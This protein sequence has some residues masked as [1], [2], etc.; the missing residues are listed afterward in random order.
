MRAFITHYRIRMQAC[1]RA[2]FALAVLLFSG[3]LSVLY[4]PT[5][6]AP[7]VLGGPLLSAEQGINEGALL[8]IWIYIWPMLA[9]TLARGSSAADDREAMGHVLLPALPVGMKTRILAET[10]LVLTVVLVLQ[11]PLFLLG[12]SMREYFYLPS[13]VD[14]G[15]AD[16]GL[17][18]RRLV[19]G[20]L[21]MLPSTAMWVAP[22]RSMHFYFMIRPLAVM[23]LLFLAMKI[24]WLAAPTGCAV[25]CLA[26]FGLVL[27]SV[28]WERDRTFSWKSRSTRTEAIYRPGLDP[29][30]RL[31]RDFWL[32][33]VLPLV[34]RRGLE[35]AG[36]I[37][38]QWFG[39]PEMG[40]YLYTCL[41]MS[42]VLS[43]V[44]L[45]PMGIPLIEA[46]GG[47]GLAAGA[48]GR[49]ARAHEV[50]PVRR[51]AVTRGI[52]LHGLLTGLLIWGTVVGVNLLTTWLNLGEL[53]MVDIDG[54]SADKYILPYI[55]VVPCLAG[56]LTS[57]AMRDLGRVMVCMAAG[58][59]IFLGHTL[60]LILDATTWLHAG[61]L[62]GL[63]L[64]GGIVPLNYL[65][66]PGP[67][68]ERR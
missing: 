10:L 11:A 4:W 60:C 45:K 52:Y 3:L 22:A 35:P 68:D 2:P 5:L 16:L 37:Y 61:L 54:D 51:E 36:L 53:R 58:G 40:F 20:T 29:D 12:G 38:D 44:V 17:L 63:A 67:A 14:Y 59:G 64:L 25:T 34:V 43:L 6:M 50:L 7:G 15:T 48:A 30:Q 62:V 39:F 66:R 13:L 23:V 32:K 47:L 26:L 41:V 28:D 9:G 18:A 55:A 31:R 1:F 19:F 8:L 57:S 27:L 46:G 24:G 33:P 42:G 65:R 56:A 49:Q 21:I